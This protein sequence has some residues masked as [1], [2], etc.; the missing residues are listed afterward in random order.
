[1]LEV[2]ELSMCK[3]ANEVHYQLVMIAYNAI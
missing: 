1:L 3:L 2:G